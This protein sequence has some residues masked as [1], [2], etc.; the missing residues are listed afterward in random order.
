MVGRIHDNLSCDTPPDSSSLLI[1]LV[2]NDTHSMNEYHFLRRLETIA[3]ALHGDC[4]SCMCAAT[5]CCEISTSVVLRDR[6]NESCASLASRSLEK[7]IACAL[8]GNCSCCLC[9]DTLLRDQHICCAERSQQCAVCI[10]RLAELFPPDPG[11]NESSL[12]V[13]VSAV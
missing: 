11:T 9:C 2:E 6:S 13:E 5:H 3:C 7:T 12:I 8:H 10:L 4:P 1:L